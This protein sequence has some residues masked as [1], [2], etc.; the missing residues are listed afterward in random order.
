[1]LFRRQQFRSISSRRYRSHTASISPAKVSRAGQIFN[2]LWKNPVFLWRPWKEEV[3]DD[4]DGDDGDDGD[5]G[6]EE[7]IL[8]V[9]VVVVPLVV[10][11]TFNSISKF[12]S[13]VFLA[14][15]WKEEAEDDAAEAIFL[16]L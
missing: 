4:A 5:D 14:R 3:E 10:T 13:P 11:L 16:L 12:N 7:A 8:A 6:E 1:M 2:S 9:V 15:R